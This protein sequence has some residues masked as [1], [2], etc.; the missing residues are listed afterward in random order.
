MYGYK[1]FCIT[2]NIGLTASTAGDSNLVCSIPSGCH[3][4]GETVVC[5]CTAV[6]GTPAIEWKGSI[7][8]IGDGSCASIAVLPAGN[9]V[10]WQCKGVEARGYSA[11]DG[12]FVSRMNFT[13]SRLHNGRTVECYIDH[14]PSPKQ[15]QT[16]IGNT[17][18]KTTPGTKM[19][20]IKN[21]CDCVIIVI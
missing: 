18:I 6:A 13:A 8:G 3:C 1:W 21:T 10:S 14:G 9:S 12:H 17:T 15:Q 7:F 16:L 19:Y 11:P 2:I 20:T 5:T 4:P